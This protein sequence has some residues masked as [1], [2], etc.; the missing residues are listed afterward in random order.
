M[1]ARYMTRSHSPRIHGILWFC[2]D[3]LPILLIACV[4]AIA[5]YLDSTKV[6][7]IDPTSLAATMIASG[8]FSCAVLEAMKRLFRIRGLYQQRQAR[9][10]FAAQARKQLEPKSRRPY[11]E[12]FPDF[13]RRPHDEEFLDF[14]RISPSGKSPVIELAGF[15]LIDLSGKWAVME[16]LTVAGVVG[17]HDVRSSLRSRRSFGTILEGLLVF[18][19]P[20]EQLTAQVAEAADKALENPK[21]YPALTFVLLGD[22]FEPGSKQEPVAAADNIRR[23]LDLFQIS[24]G[25]RWRRYISASALALSGLVSLAITA[26]SPDY[27]SGFFITSV[28]AVFIG[29]FIS[30]VIRDI[31]AGIERWRR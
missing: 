31:A 24:I 3:V 14:R 19:L 20:I 25:Q 28:G 13:G 10:W 27:S 29:G 18:D 7:V 12:E 16:V 5:Y 9:R 11:D 23:H 6:P 2:L 30:W 1:G 26:T 4:L 8:L 22:S 17:S 15:G 21:K